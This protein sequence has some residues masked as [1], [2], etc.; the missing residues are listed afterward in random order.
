M[1][2]SIQALRTLAAWLVVFHHYLQIVQNNQLT[3]PLPTALHLYGNIGVDLFFIISGFVIYLS[4][5]EKN[6]TPTTFAMHRLSRIVPAYWLF[7]LISSEILLTAPTFI[8]LTQFEPIFLLKSLFFIPAQN[9]SGIGLF[10]L[11]TVGW[12][13]N[14][15]MIFYTVFLLCLFLPKSFRL[16]GLFIGIIVLQNFSTK[17]GS[18][19]KFYENKIIYEFLIGI[20][21]ALA[22][23]IGLIQRL[24][25]LAAVAL[26]ITAGWMLVHFGPVTHNPWTFGIACALI[27]IAA[28][29]KE[30]LFDK[31][32]W[33]TK[34]G[35]WSYSTYLCHVLI[36]CCWMAIQIRF[37][38]DETLT[39]S[40]IIVSILAV[41]WASFTF[42]ERPI[43]RFVKSTS[44]KTVQKP[45]T[46]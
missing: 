31:L 17:L 5:F 40:L 32:G 44:K 8:P 16:P 7:T 36:M 46:P 18:N 24:N 14:Y 1:L 23:K 34:L 27:V 6:I 37:N 45:I 9:P 13:L 10:P 11:L 41:S 39:F 42:I 2:N 30:K 29:S 43:S 35:D 26:T 28:I 15:E 25:S 21:I 33:I 3:G 4:A 19:F 22:Y 20:A 12:T 38:L